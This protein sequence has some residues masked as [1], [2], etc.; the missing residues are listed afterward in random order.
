VK[1]ITIVAFIMIL[2]IFCY[3]H[4]ARAYDPCNPSAIKPQKTQTRLGSMYIS[5][6]IV[7]VGELTTIM[8]KNEPGNLRLNI[9][10]PNDTELIDY[11][12]KENYITN[13]QWAS[14]DNTLPAGEYSITIRINHWTNK[15]WVTAGYNITNIQ[16]MGHGS[17]HFFA[18][19]DTA[20][21]DIILDERNQVPQT[22]KDVVRK[23]EV[24]SPKD[25]TINLSTDKGEIG[26]SINEKMGKSAQLIS[27]QEGIAAF[28]LFAKE[29]ERIKLT[30]S[31][32]DT[33]Q[34]SSKT[35]TFNIRR[36]DISRSYQ[37]QDW[38][39]YVIGLA[40]IAIVSLIVIIKKKK[41]KFD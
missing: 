10:I 16:G 14:H 19:Y 29:G 39:Y 2:T 24:L 20:S 33:C 1:K 26:T 23:I 18:Y 37:N 35:Q 30:A 17:D 27:N 3:T 6:D 5:P 4:I 28:Y 12:P 40:V 25:I 15:Q 31:S 13:G 21:L 34:I 8:V 11:F 38:I 36:S 32:P 9:L 22:T 41:K 7:P